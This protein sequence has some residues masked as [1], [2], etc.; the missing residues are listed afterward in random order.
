MVHPNILR[1]YGIYQD[2][3]GEMFIVTELMALGNLKDL[4]R[5]RREEI[6]VGDL[7]QM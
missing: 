1:F 7:V 6:N 5:K 2:A 4:L 3:N